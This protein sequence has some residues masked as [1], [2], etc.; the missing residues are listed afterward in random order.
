[1]SNAGYEL[2]N[3]IKTSNRNG[4]STFYLHIFVHV[5]Q[6][7]R[8]TY[9]YARIIIKGKDAIKLKAADIGEVPG[10]KLRRASWRK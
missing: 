7:D 8:Q 10:G 4:L 3:P 9:V 2:W 1:M 5:L 6:A